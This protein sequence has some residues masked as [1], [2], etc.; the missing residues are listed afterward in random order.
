MQLKMADYLRECEQCLFNIGTR[1]CKL[2]TCE[3]FPYCWIHM[4]KVFGLMAKPSTIKGAGLGLF[5]VGYKDGDAWVD[6]LKRND[7][8]T[9]YSAKTL[10]TPRQYQ[11]K[12]GDADTAYGFT[13]RGQKYVLDSG[14][15]AN[16]PGRLINNHRNPA[17]I[18]VR[19]SESPKKPP[20]LHHRYVHRI[21]A[22][23]PIRAGEELFIDY[24]DEYWEGQEHA[25]K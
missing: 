24:G 11:N 13:L 4:K 3:R 12:Y 16:Y 10:L 25:R 15:T 7:T 17:R 19:F 5:F 8:V 20:Q 2:R 23:K 9:F 6:R 22:T 14:S 18:N 1:R 21:F